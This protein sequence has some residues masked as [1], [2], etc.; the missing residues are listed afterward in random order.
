MSIRVLINEITFFDDLLSI[1]ETSLKLVAKLSTPRMLSAE[2]HGVIS[3][4]ET[5]LAVDLRRDPSTQKYVV[6]IQSESIPILGI[7]KQL[8]AA[9]VP[10]DLELFLGQVFNINICKNYISICSFAT[11]TTDFWYSTIVGS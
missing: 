3:L 11:T 1:S 6:V 8:G 2:I 7:V 4:G 5:D 10:D 9:L